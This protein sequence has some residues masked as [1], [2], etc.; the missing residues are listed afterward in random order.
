MTSYLY[1]SFNY[2][3]SSLFN[4]VYFCTNVNVF[5]FFCHIIEKLAPWIFTKAIP[6]HISKPIF[7]NLNVEVTHILLFCI[8][9]FMYVFNSMFVRDH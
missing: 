6:A 3:F 5:C 9:V 1:N 7:H 8:H 4:I 2:Y